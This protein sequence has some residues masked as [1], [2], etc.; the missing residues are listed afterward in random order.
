MEP[1]PPS[2]Y[3]QHRNETDHHQKSGM[4][5]SNANNPHSSQSYTTNQPKTG[6]NVSHVQSHM[7]RERTFTGDRRRPHSGRDR[8]N[9]AERQ[10]HSSRD[11][12]NTVERRPHSGK[13]HHTNML[14]R[15]PH[16]S[17][18]HRTNMSE[19]RP[20]SGRDRSRTIES[21]S[22]SGRNV[23][24]I[25]NSMPKQRTK[26]NRPKLPNEAWGN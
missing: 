4:P 25:G 9:T 2:D 7:G 12:A 10:P 23:H 24:A 3:R 17:R 8:A 15:R 22:H 16:S 21:R 13:N 1:T 26:S 5:N 6:I 19:R 11:R 14:E 18:D 20:H